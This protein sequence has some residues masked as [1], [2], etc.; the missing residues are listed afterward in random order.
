[1]SYICPVCGYPEL[2][3]DPESLTSHEICL[4]CDFEF[5]VT[6][7]DEGYTYEQW[8]DKW[9][10]EGMI[11]DKG[12]TEPPAGWDPEKQLENLKKI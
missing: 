10:K 6:D 1:M 7:N 3:R 5:R 12:E 2:S 11:W 8:R 9:I 4:C